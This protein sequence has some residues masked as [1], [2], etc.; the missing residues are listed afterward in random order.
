MEIA[1]EAHQVRVSELPASAPAPM[2]ESVAATSLDTLL[3][4]LH[5]ALVHAQSRIDELERS[6]AAAPGA[7]ASAVAEVLQ[8]DEVFLES[9]RGGAGDGGD[10]GVPNAMDSTLRGFVSVAGI[11]FLE[12]GDPPE[13]VTDRVVVADKVEDETGLLVTWFDHYDGVHKNGSVCQWEITFN[14]SAC[15]DPGPIV[16]R[17]QLTS[18]TN[19]RMQRSGTVVGFCTE[20]GVHPLD[21]GEVE[22]A[23]R[24]YGDRCVTGDAA[25][26]SFLSVHEMA[27]P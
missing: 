4:D 19:G 18:G 25:Q 17:V 3:A 16:Y 9:V 13:P 6:L 15:T 1:A 11:H 2:P 27:S 7:N 22:V 26:T 8:A 12:E 21:A 20:A 5:G 14:G 10:G 24:V 23:T